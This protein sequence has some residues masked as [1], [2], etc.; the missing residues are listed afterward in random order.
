[1]GVFLHT[2]TELNILF[3]KIDDFNYFYPPNFEY[4]VPSRSTPT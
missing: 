4:Y 3:L 2:K 1:M